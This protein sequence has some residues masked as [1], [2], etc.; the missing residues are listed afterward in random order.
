MAN[1]L[2]A[3]G[4]MFLLYLLL[5]RVALCGQLGAVNFDKNGAFS[6]EASGESRIMGS[7][8][9][10]HG[11]WKYA[12][13][14]PVESVESD[15]WRGTIPEPGV[16]SGYISY[17]QTVKPTPDGGADISLD[18]RQNGEIHL[19]RGIFLLIQFQGKGMSQRVIEFTHGPPSA[20]SDDYRIAAR[21]F[22]VNISDSAALEFKLDRASLFARHK[23]FLRAVD[24]VSFEIQKG[25]TLGLVGESGSGKTTLGRAILRLIEPTGGRIIF[26]IVAVPD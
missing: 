14:P 3:M 2:K 5:P 25:E 9:L 24:G 23:A 8:F 13:P 11:E 16:T 7:L 4:L 20:V 17:T 10:W 22:G 1:V 18:F 15:S 19:T 21:G 26:T 6:V 12:T